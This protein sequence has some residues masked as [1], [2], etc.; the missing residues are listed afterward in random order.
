[1]P[2]GNPGIPGITGLFDIRLS[3]TTTT[4]IPTWS[5]P[6]ASSATTVVTFSGCTVGTLAFGTPASLISSGLIFT[7]SGFGVD[8]ILLTAAN[9]SAS[10]ATQ[11]A[12]VWTF[13]RVLTVAR[14]NPANV[15]T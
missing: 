1:M 7:V 5:I 3:S 8:N 14:A 11:I 9:V 10:T 4:Q 13:A 6:N 12:N 15:P 2:V